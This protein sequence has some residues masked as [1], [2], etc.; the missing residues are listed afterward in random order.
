MVESGDV[1]NIKG[2]ELKAGDT[3]KFDVFTPS[4][5]V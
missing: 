3:I 1:I 2:L 4:E 5:T